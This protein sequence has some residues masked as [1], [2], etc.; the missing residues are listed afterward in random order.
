MVRAR[1]GDTVRVH[2]T[3][4]LSDGSI[5]DSSHGRE[6][7]E[8]TLGAGRVIAGFEEA[9][10]GMAPGEERK[11]TVPAAQAYGSR[12]DEL[13]FEVPRAQ[14]PDDLQPAV[15]L[16]VQL[17]QGG[18][19]AVARIAEVT[20][21]TVTLDANHPLAGRDLTFDLELVGIAES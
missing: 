5:F 12:R 11:V 2:Y 15:G 14:F 19:R 9:V 6:P 20:E 3:G 1:E 21:E 8:F 13:V 4:T 18:Q 17:T 7:L 16:E 10:N